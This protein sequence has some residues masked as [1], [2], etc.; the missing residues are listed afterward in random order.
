M[1][2]LLEKPTRARLFAL[3]T[4]VAAASCGEDRDVE[5]VV[6]T[7]HET[8]ALAIDPAIET[9]RIVA[10]FPIEDEENGTLEATA[11]RGESF[12]LGTIPDDVPIKLDV[13]G[14]LADGTEVA[15]GRSASLVAGSISTGQ[16]PVFLQRTDGFARPP[17]EL[18]RSHAFAPAASFSERYVVMTGGKPVGDADVR[19]AEFYDL[20]TLSGQESGSALPRAAESIVV[21]DTQILLLDRAGGTW[22][23]IASGTQAE[24]T[25]PDGLVAAD[26]AGGLTFDAKDGISYVLGAT[27]ADTPTNGVLEIAENGAL[28]TRRLARPAANASATYVAGFG[29][30]IAEGGVDDALQ[31]LLPDGSSR[32]L[33]F[34]KAARAGALAP[35][36]GTTVAW[37]GSG[38]DAALCVADLSCAPSCACAPQGATPLDAFTRGRAYRTTAHWLVLG[39]TDRTV[40]YRVDQLGGVTTLPLREA[41]R[42]A[43]ISPAPNG[44]LAI[45]GGENPDDGAPVTHVEFFF[46][47]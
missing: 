37:F 35:L 11:R 22:I 46:P 23:D 9:I 8:D 29:L 15:R 24:V 39:E 13:F 45:L 33:A 1:R 26:V 32:T 41:R 12:D 17:G 43:A 7:G 25:F 27:R 44:T 40:A 21:R 16:I 6:T 14:R 4:G 20:V 28:T 36:D 47:D 34:P 3:F 10:T 42:G 30:V 18:P 38:D 5:I 31:V 19:Y 2:S